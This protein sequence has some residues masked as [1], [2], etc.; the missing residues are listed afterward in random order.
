MDLLLAVLG[1]GLLAT[2]M[3]LAANSL[4]TSAST[5]RTQYAEAVRALVAWSEYP[6]RIRRRTGDDQETLTRLAE[7]GHSLQET[8]AYHSAWIAADNTT[9]AAV[10]QQ[11]RNEL[12]GPVAKACHEAWQSPAVTA[13]SDMVLAQ[14]GPRNVVPVVT[15]VEQAIRYRFGSRRLLPATALRWCLRRRSLA[16]D[17]CGVPGAAGQRIAPDQVPT[18]PRH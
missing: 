2:A 18:T 6:Y 10:Y 7:L 3:T 1:S 9:I 12:A 4:R 8:L 11:A 16:P 17:H 15:S 13:P 5:R 14:F